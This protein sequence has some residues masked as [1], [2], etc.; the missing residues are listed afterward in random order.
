MRD[1]FAKG[2][3]PTL[4]QR[5]EFAVS[6]CDYIDEEINRLWESDNG[7]NALKCFIISFS[8]V[9]TD[10]RDI[11]RLRFP[12]AKWALV[13]VDDSTAQER[14]DQREGHFYKGAPSAGTEQIKDEAKPDVQEKDNSE[15]KFAPV[16]FDH[17][18]LNGFASIESNA[19]DVIKMLVER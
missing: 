1:N 15:W 4:E 16:D 13:D 8:F 11:F 9:N 5:N 2:I 6:A 17:V 12:G 14:I 18:I 19:D 7:D 10:L 3:Y